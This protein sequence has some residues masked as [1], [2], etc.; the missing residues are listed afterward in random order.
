MREIRLDKIKHNK[1]IIYKI[2]EM[3]ST[4]AIAF[5][6]NFINAELMTIC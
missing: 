1:Q 6:L 3:T 4:A 5:I 2:S